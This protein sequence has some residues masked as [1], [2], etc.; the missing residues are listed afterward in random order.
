MPPANTMFLEP[1]DETRSRGCGLSQCEALHDE[2]LNSAGGVLAASVPRRLASAAAG[3]SV[4]H[5]PNSP[6]AR[7]GR[8]SPQPAR[9]DLWATWLILPVAYACLKD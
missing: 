2:P 1:Y 5:N 6:E 3:G 9:F 4:E 8:A 7:V